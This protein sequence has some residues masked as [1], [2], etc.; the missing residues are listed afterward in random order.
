MRTHSVAGLALV[1][2]AT[3]VMLMPPYFNLAV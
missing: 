1:R 3:L 2:I